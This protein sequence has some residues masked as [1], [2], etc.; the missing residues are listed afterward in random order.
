M[1]LK[2][3]V[4]YV[5]PPDLDGRHEILRVHTRK[6][7]V[8]DDIDLRKIAEDTELFTGAELEGLCKEA[9]IA[10]LR[11]D[12]SASSVCNRHFHAVM[13]S[14]KPALT[15]EEINSYAS[16]SKNPFLRLSNASESSFRPEI[17][18]T[19][20]KSKRVLLAATSV[21]VPLG[22]IIL[23]SYLRGGHV[24][25]ESTTRELAST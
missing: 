2:I 1:N 7:K 21:A 25:F 15:R 9:G 4:L 22:S 5:P 18:K 11:E 13:R 8:D 20:K 10:A 12:L 19:C 16:F 14:L 17:K 23:Y 24:N 6:M 3:Q